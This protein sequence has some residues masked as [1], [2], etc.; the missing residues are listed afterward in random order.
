M[1]FLLTGLTS[2][3]FGQNEIVALDSSAP[4]SSQSLSVSTKTSSINSKYSSTFSDNNFSTRIKQFQ[5]AV[6]N[7]DVRLSSVYYPNSDGDYVINFKDSK[8]VVIATYDKNGQLISCQEHYKAV[9]LPY[10]VSSKIVKE[11]PNWGVKTVDCDIVYSDKNQK[12]TIEY[13]VT[14]N[15]ENKTKLITIVL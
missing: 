3:S 13:K 4:K 1:V 11:Y 2:L 7:Y 12:S 6:A 5:N 9:I 10:A 8:N 14:I 15:N